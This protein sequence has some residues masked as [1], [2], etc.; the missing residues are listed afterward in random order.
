MLCAYFA[1][2]LAIP[3]NAAITLPTE[4]LTTGA[5]I[6]PN[7]L[8]ILDDSGSMSSTY[9]PDAVPATSSPNIASQAYTRNTIY[10]NPA[11]TYTPWVDSTGTLRTDAATYGSVYSDAALARGT[12]INLASAVQ[13]F[14]VPKDTSATSETYLANPANYYRYQILT[15]S[16]IYQAT[17][18]TYT[19][20][21]TPSNAGSMGCSTDTKANTLAWRGCI[22]LTPLGG[23]RTEA[24]ERTN[25]AIWYSYHRTRAK[26]AKAGAGKAFSSLGSNIRVGFRTINK[27]AGASSNSITE[28][29]PIPVS[30]NDG[31]FDDPSG[32]NGD[33]NNRTQWFDRLYT[34]PGTSSTT[35]LRGALTRAG[36][37]FSSGSASGAYGPQSGADQYTCR[38]NFTILTTDGYWNESNY[39]GQSGEQD[40]VAGATITNANNDSYTYEPVRPYASADSYGGQGNLADVA[41]RYWKNDLRTDMENNVPTTNADPAFWQHMVTFGISIGEKGTLN[42]ATDLPAITAGTKSWPATSNNSIVNIDD[43][44][45]ATINGRGDFVVATDPDGFVQGITSALSAITE[46]T[47]SFS[48]VSASSTSLNS[49]TRLFQATYKSGLWTGDVAAY[50]VSASGVATTASW[51]AS[52]RIPATNRKIFTSD[53][54]AGAVFPTAAQ[55]AALERVGTT[56]YPVTG[57][58]NAAYISG[59]RT[60]ELQNGGSL[61]NRVQVLGDIVSSSPAYVSDTDTL[62]VGANDGML[63][64][65]NAASGV[66]LFGFIPS[67][68]SLANLNTLSRPDYAHRFFVDGPVVAS[69]RTQTPNKNILVAALGKGGKGLFALD[70]TNPAAFT[71]AN[72]KWEAGTSDADMGLVQARPFITK[73]NNGVTALI[74]SNGLN[75]TNGRAVLFIYNLDTGALIR[76]IDT[77]IGSAVTDSADSNGLSESVG[78][79]ADG[80]GTVDYVYAGDMLG[81]VWKFN[82][83]ATTSASWGVSGNAPIFS[84]TYT[85][86][87]PATRQPITGGLTVAMHPTTYQTWVFFGTGRLMTSG[88]MTNKAVQTIYGFVDDGT[89]K[90]R[91][92][93]AANLTS[94]SLVV[95]SSGLR[96]FQANAALPAGSKGW[97]VDLL[98][99]PNGTVEGERVV[100]GPQLLSDVLVFSSVIPTASACTPDGIGY[101]NALDAFTGTGTSSPFF[102]ANGNGNFSDDTLASGSGTKLPVGSVNPGIGMTTQPSLLNGLVTVGGSS[103]SM[104]NLK[105]P[106]ARNVGR[107]SWREVKKGD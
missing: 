47:G 18:E 2:L 97:Y 14:Y 43:L 34:V 63:H 42:P 82:L 50:A 8:F 52:E 41:M 92:G 55:T 72:F 83:S 38:Q 106:E 12:T 68:I 104:A 46:R 87:T 15:D 57:A 23:L 101:L 75:S 27:G 16:K 61:R 84:A 85:G 37:Y 94:R 102:D 99:P 88:D 44:W 91:S 35:P 10:Y 7:V 25:Y 95:T 48:N 62:Y 24:A 30:R 79:D 28:S 39:T 9:M 59:T 64:A 58:E 17:Y 31:L 80:S 67:G 98:T 96:S 1:T 103:G 105:I 73:L 90:S 13:T 51:R 22:N 11:T 65:F 54:T 100:S 60:L 71:A 93:T 45:H 53:G 69:S 107:V 5:R 56:N 76:K 21:N 40:N 4:P 20:S 36:E 78:W 6:P 29:A 81:N 49:G 32:V 26:I 74:V 3:V 77:G 86:A 70:V 33:N 19:K 66:E 89:A